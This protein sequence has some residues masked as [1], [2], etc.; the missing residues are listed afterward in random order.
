MNVPLKNNVSLSSDAEI[1]VRGLKQ[2]TVG[3]VSV[4]NNKVELT[5]EK[6][7]GVEIVGET[8]IKVPIEE[9]EDDYVELTDDNEVDKIVE[10]IDTE[11]LN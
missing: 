8:K 1:I 4:N 7:L 9:D 6:E 11:Y 2:P 3:D 5:I 10:E